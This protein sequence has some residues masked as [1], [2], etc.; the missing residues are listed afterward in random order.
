M[1]KVSV[2]IPIY[3]VEKY[4]ERCARSLFEQTLDDIEFIFIDDCSP[5]R[6][7]DLLRLIALEYKQHNEEKRHII[8]IEKMLSNSGLAAVRQYGIQLA[9]GDYIAHCDS[10]DWVDIDMYFQMYN[11]A[12]TN[13][14]DVVICDYVLTN[15]TSELE[16][17]EACHSD[18]PIKEI[19]N[20]LLQ[21]DPWSLWNKL[22]IKKVYSNIEYPKGAMGEDMATTIQLL[23]N[24][25]SLSYISK[26]FYK[27]YFNPDS[28]TKKTTREN[29]IKRFEQLSKNTE[30]VLN[31]LEGNNAKIFDEELVVYKNFIRSVLYPLVYDQ[32][33]YILWNTMFADLNKQALLSTKISV[34]E[35]IRIILTMLHLYPRKRDRAIL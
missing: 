27:Y 31:F 26:P 13:N 14:S 3:K 17:V 15:G 18:T 29:C 12:I 34:F 11:N 2:I 8:R 10:D 25:R 21:R 16:T 23:W 30:V 24:C 22:F 32:K 7:I 5:D 20:C 6:S 9:T 1:P 33:Y 19:E 28:I 4:I 35:K